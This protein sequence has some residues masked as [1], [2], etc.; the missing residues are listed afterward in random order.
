MYLEYDNV[1][2]YI[3]FQSDTHIEEKIKYCIETNAHT[4]NVLHFSFDN[5]SINFNIRSYH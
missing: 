3:F 1:T 4:D 2:Y 5:L